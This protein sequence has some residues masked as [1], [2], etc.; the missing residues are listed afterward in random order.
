MTKALTREPA[1]RWLLWIDGVGAFALFLDD[2]VRFGGPGSTGKS[3]DVCLLAHLSREH[4]T[5]RRSGEGYLMEAQ[6]AA[7]VAGR[8]VVGSVPLFD[9]CEIALGRSV[10]LRFRQPNV[11]SA[12]ARIEFLSD[13]RPRRSID[14]VILMHETCILGPAAD[15]HVPCP[16][17]PD[18]VLLFR[19]Q[20][21]LWCRSRLRLLVG[22]QFVG[23]G[24]PLRS[25]QTVVGAGLRFRLEAV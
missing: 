15:A 18:S 19:R 5:I 12:T 4:A 1:S 7:A 8:D 25:G 9:G 2:R 3:A 23:D 6:G 21:Q 17:W 20:G 22:E 24:R 10:R 14:G 13:H 16:D 11:L